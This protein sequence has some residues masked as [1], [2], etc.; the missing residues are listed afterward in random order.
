MSNMYKRIDA[1]CKNSYMTV[2]DLCR[3]LKI[4]RS[5][6]SELSRGRSQK[7]NAVSTAKIAE[8]FGVS[9]SYLTE[10]IPEAFSKH[11]ISD[12]PKREQIK[13][14][15]RN[16]VNHPEIYSLQERI[17][18]QIKIFECL[19]SRSYIQQGYDPNHVTFDEYISLLLGQE[20]TKENMDLDLFNALT[21]KYGKKK[22]MKEGT[23]YALN[24]N[25]SKQPIIDVNSIQYA[26][27]AALEGESEE[28]QQDIL[29]YIKF[30]KSQKKD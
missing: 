19:F 24:N 16:I 12:Y 20:H 4:G 7:L 5:S 1:L 23:S 27:Y 8:Y 10:G 15:N 2:T 17:E 25:N 21:M 13:A 11:I 29:D 18:A 26:A 30:K 22:G 9:P 3:E 28:F 6:L 14:E